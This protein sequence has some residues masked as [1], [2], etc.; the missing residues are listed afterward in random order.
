MRGYRWAILL[1]ALLSAGLLTGASLAIL[2]T[3][4]Q[5]TIQC[6]VLA[7]TPEAADGVGLTLP[8]S[9]GN[10]MF[11]TTTFPAGRP[12]EAETD[13]TSTLSQDP[14][15]KPWAGQPLSVE[16]ADVYYWGGTPD[17]PHALLDSLIQQAQ[18]TTPEGTEA[19]VSFRIRDYFDTWPLRVTSD[20]PGIQYDLWGNSNLQ[21]LFQDY[22]AIPVS[23]DA[24]FTVTVQGS[25][26]SYDTGCIP[27]LKSYAAPCGDTI[28]FVLTN[29]ASVTVKDEVGN[30][31]QTEL[32]L[33][34]SA[35]PG[36]WG[37][38][39][40]TPG[41]EDTLGTLETLWSLPEGADILDF[42]GTEDEADFFLL[43]R[44]EGQLRLRVFDGEGN[45]RQTMDLLPFSV[46]E[47]YMQTYKG[48]GFLVPMIYGPRAEGYCYHFAVL[49]KAGGTW[50]TAFT[51]DDRKAAQLGCG[52]FTWTDDTYSCLA[53]AWDGERLAVWDSELRNGSLFHL[54]VYSRDGLDY[55]ATYQNSVSQASDNSAGPVYYA[56]TQLF[57]L[58]T[59]Q[60]R[61]AKTGS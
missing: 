19:T 28:L 51:G 59:P 60:V 24:T 42:W 18:E 16:V 61:W 54:A 8:L 36:D 27:K 29:I 11:W 14:R 45:L 44:E 56:F 23:S 4:D 5:V 37:L 38:Y 32:A 10:Q 9:C 43:T 40:Y 25:G 3:A 55:L 49:H 17:N 15:T 34:G 35:I 2:D 50:Q 46:E 20:L 22:F 39:R 12:E 41:P 6:E 33:D 57:W 31:Q 30:F 7:G 53:M 58:E 13:F 1:L 47:S 26:A 52:G 48:D 21:Q